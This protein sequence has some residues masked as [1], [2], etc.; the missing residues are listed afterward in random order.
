MPLSRVHDVIQTAMGWQD[1]HL[2]SFTDGTRTYGYPDPELGF[3]DERTVRFGDLDVDRG[4]TGLTRT[5]RPLII[6]GDGGREFFHCMRGQVSLDHIPS[7][8]TARSRVLVARCDVRRVAGADGAIR[9]ETQAHWWRGVVEDADG[10][11]ARREAVAR[12]AC[13]WAPS[14]PDAIS[15]RHRGDTP[16]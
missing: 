2:H 16:R 13:R 6:G 5:A 14:G 10:R 15:T 9:V 4:G 1:H 7:S 3:V 8:R 11:P 12:L